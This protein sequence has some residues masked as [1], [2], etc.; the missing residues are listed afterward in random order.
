MTYKRQML[1]AER[2][3]VEILNGLEAFKKHLELAGRSVD[4][5]GSIIPHEL[6]PVADRVTEELL[7]VLVLLREGRVP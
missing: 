4:A 3:V 7:S 2:D 6:I 1:W 5:G